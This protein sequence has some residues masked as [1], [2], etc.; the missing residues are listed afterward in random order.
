MLHIAIYLVDVSLYCNFLA[1]GFV[2]LAYWYASFLNVRVPN[3]IIDG[4]SSC[5]LV[6]LF[7]KRKEETKTIL[8]IMS[9]CCTVSKQRQIEKK[10]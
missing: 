8:I 7:L 9:V 4:V 10:P 2:M 6:Y 3:G 1:E 5:F